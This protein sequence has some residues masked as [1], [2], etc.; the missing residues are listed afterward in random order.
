MTAPRK[1][2][3][4]RKAK[5]VSG[6]V[7]ILGRPNAGKSTLLNALAGAKLAIVASRPQTTRTL[8]QGVWTSE[9]AQVVFLDTP[10]IHDARTKFNRWM[11]ESVA[12]A[13]KE[14]DLLL[15]VIDATR[16]PEPEDEQAV[17]LVRQAGAPA[18]AVFNKVDALGRKS[19]LLPLLD[20]YRQWHAFAG[21][22]P[23][24]AL[25]GEGVDEL[26]AAVAARMPAGPRWFPPGHLTDQPERFLAAEIIRE[27]LLHRTRQEV[28][29]AMA[30]LVDEWKED[31]R[32][33]R[34]AATIHVERPGQKAIVVGAGGAR[35]KEA[36]SEARLELEAIL[37]RRV[38][39]SLFVKVT[40]DW[41]ENERFLKELDWRSMRGAEAPAGQD[42]D[43]PAARG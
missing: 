31:G 24:S 15:F 21:Y 41:R 9:E 5:F 8:I 32:L 7:S 26:R 3:R 2:S 23:V 20:R 43:G 14:R 16:A 36:G 34:I 29:H 28:P 12:E 6:F 1:R 13:L 38:F 4:T 10:G 37:G 19:A 17:E 39:L 18:F 30:V 35:L 25:S 27:K 33:V 40:P 22:F 11:M 42:Q